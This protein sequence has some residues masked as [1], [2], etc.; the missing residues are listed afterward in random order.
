MLY[1]NGAVVK[2]RVEDAPDVEIV[3]RYDNDGK[4]I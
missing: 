4:I 3:N 2:S 1:D